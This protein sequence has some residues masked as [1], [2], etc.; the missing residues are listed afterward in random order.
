MSSVQ[1][2]PVSKE[3]FNPWLHYQHWAD[4]VLTFGFPQDATHFPGFP[5][6]QLRALS[7]SQQD[8][9][10]GILTDISS[11]T[12]LGF[13]ES[14]APTLRY[15][16][17]RKAYG[18]SAFFP[19][20]DGSGGDAFFGP[21]TDD[22]VPGNESYLYF[23]H[24]IGHTLGLEH[25]HIYKRF[26]RSD[27]NSQEFS[28]M[29]YADYV[30]DTDITSYDSGKIDWAQSYMQ[31]D[32]AALQFL[33]G[34]NYAESG[35]GWSGDTTYGFD[36]QTGEMSINNHG[37][38]DVAGNR[39]F[40]T[41]WDGDGNDTYDLGNYATNLSLDLRPGKFSTFSPAQLA[42]LNRFDDDPAFM[43]RG[44]LANARLV[45]GDERAL[46][47]NA[48][49]GTGNDRIRGN[50]ADNTLSGNEGNDRIFGGKGEDLLLGENGRDRLKGNGGWDELCGGMGDDRLKGGKGVDVL[51]GED[52]DD[53]LFGGRGRDTINGGAGS[54][55]LT[56]GGGRDTFVFD[57]IGR[58]GENTVRDFTTGKDKIDLTGVSEFDLELKVNGTF[59]VSMATVISVQ[60]TDGTLI[61]VDRDG[62]EHSDLSIFLSQVFELREGDFLL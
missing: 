48:L 19:S 2:T 23:I 34:A 22:P 41:I 50:D 27:Y 31:F 53:L 47:E 14:K 24:E 42:D 46:I 4:P 13:E 16:T 30:G 1:A 17:D 6:N 52:G 15:I 43:A 61:E 35:F 62:D 20:A 40:R 55:H 38:G 59:A 60:E 39:I 33:Y 51:N 36:P 10:R 26:S 7:D 5:V 32:I 9:V 18:A 56:G 29:T 54:N 12:L 37:Q 8:A 28:I 21:N 45:D 57:A 44:N 11:F 58:G 3:P 25:G 49:G